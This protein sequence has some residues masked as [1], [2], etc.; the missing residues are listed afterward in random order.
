MQLVIILFK[1]TYV[2]DIFNCGV[3]TCSVFVMNSS[4]Y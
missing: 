4:V 3:S 1:I 2:S